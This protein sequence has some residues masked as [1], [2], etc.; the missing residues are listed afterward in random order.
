MLGIQTRGTPGISFPFGGIVVVLFTS[1]IVFI[2]SACSNPF[3]SG[4]TNPCGSGLIVP[5]ECIDGV[6]LGD[7]REAVKELL[8]EPA[9]TG[10]ADGFYRSWLVFTYYKP[11]G[12]DERGFNIFFIEQPI[13]EVGPVDA[14]SVHEPYQGQT[15]EGICLGSM[16]DEVREAYGEPDFTY[17]T[18]LSSGT[19][20]NFTYCIKN[21]RFNV[22]M[23]EDT[24]KGFFIGF[25]NPMEQ[26]TVINCR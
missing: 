25:H 11:P 1:L 9:S 18:E 24:V 13:N 8:G 19:S 7:S 26:D 10:L 12:S 5:G 17:E 6:K 14:L 4:E 16:M 15:P 3:S 21:R 2:A 20:T 22:G 23:L